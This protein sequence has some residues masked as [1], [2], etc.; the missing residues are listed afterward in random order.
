MTLQYL[1]GLSSIFATYYITLPDYIVQQK[2]WQFPNIFKLEQFMHTN[3]CAKLDKLLVGLGLLCQHNF[4]YTYETRNRM[5]RNQ[6][7][8]C[9]L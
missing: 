6:L 9:L 2:Q 3:Q 5:E 4:G 8:M 7:G 1:V